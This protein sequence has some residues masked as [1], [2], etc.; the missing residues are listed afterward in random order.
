MDDDKMTEKT[1]VEGFVPVSSAPVFWKS[2]KRSE[3]RHS[4]NDLTA[5]QLFCEGF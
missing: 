2:R 1:V 4:V 5:I 3:F